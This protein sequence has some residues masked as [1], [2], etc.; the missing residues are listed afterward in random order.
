MDAVKSPIVAISSEFMNAFAAVPKKMQAKVLDFIT[1]LRANPT[2]ASINYEKIV[3]FKDKT[4]RS[5]RIDQT[6][7]AIVKKPDTGNVYM[8]L[9]VDHHDKAYEWAKNRK[10]NINPETG[11]LQVYDVDEQQIEAVMLSRSQQG[12]MRKKRACLKISITGI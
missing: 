12:T 5:V 1:K 4:L 3:Q 11:S 2:A 8:L 10:C 9:W 6:Y 7:R